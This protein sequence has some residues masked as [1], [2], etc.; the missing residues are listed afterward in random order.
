MLKI[1]IDYKSLFQKSSPKIKDDFA[2]YLVNGYQGT[3]KTWFCVYDV[4]NKWKSRKIKTNIRSLRIKGYEVEYF[5]QLQDI[6]NDTDNNVVYV[7]D[8]LSKK[9][10]KNS[11]LDKH[12]YSWLQQSRKHSRYV[13]LI[14]QEYINVPNWLRGV[15]NRVFTTSK[16]P[17]LNLFCT[18]LGVPELDKETF[19]WGCVPILKIFY[20]RTKKISDM[21][22][23]LESIDTL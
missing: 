14:T 10:N 23:T 6:Y 1:K 5:S 21:Y 19:E 12:F 8:E 16:V 20:K 3:G 13:Y 4:Y 22:D 17:L 18:T 7:I 11:P 2:I 9:Y 15:A